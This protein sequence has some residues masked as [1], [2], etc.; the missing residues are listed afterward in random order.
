MPGR[1]TLAIVPPKARKRIRR[2]LRQGGAD[3]TV[4]SASEC[5]ARRERSGRPTYSYVFG[6]YAEPIATRHPGEVLD[7]YT[8]DAFES[9]VQSEDDLP[10][11]GPELPVPQPA[12]RADLRRGRR[13]G[14]HAR[15]RDHRDRADA[16][17]RRERPHSLLRRAHRD[18]DDGAPARSPAGARLHLS[19]RDGTI[20]LPRGIRIPYEPFMG[21]IATAPEIEAISTLV[22][23]RSEGT[24]TSPTCV[25]GNTVRLPGARRRRV[26]L[27]RGRPRGAG[28][29]RALRRR[30][31][32]DR[33]GP[34]RLGLEKGRRSPGRGSSRRP[35]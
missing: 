23:G 16:R 24:W 18:A 11:E 7:I 27:H 34:P 6:P 32:D 22:P 4:D 33:A 25:P 2:S 13:E 19:A 8:E 1:R 17:L 29:R 35:S 26:L 28:R 21:T 9:R 12:D 31:R 14:R 10:T 3:S 15:G 5:R 20:E 30:L